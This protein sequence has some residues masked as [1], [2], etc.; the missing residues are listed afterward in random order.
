MESGKTVSSEWQDEQFIFD[1]LHDYIQGGS[2]GDI[3]QLRRAFHP[4]ALVRSV[5]DGELIQWSLEQYLDI[6]AGATPRQRR[7]EILFIGREGET[8]FARLRL[9]YSDFEF[10]DSF[11]L[12]KLL[13]KWVIVDK[14]FHRQAY[15]ANANPAKIS[16][17]E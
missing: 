4:G 8:A 2:T 16:K 5:R 1:T 7:P 10:V 3:E 6:V 14:I 12:A 17:T 9:I 13:G 15:P 11:H